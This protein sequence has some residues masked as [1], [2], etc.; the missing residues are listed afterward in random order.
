L[1]QSWF[2]RVVAMV[3]QE[4][5]LYARTVYENIVMGLGEDSIV[6]N[7][8]AASSTRDPTSLESMPK[9]TL[10]DVQEACK[11]ANAHHFIM[12]MPDGYDTEVRE[13]LLHHHT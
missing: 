11:L 3:A 4:P 12:A 7:N 10:A 5:V 2:H 8:T 13:S 9:P 6:A 1:N